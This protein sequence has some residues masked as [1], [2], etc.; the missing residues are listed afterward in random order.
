MSAEQIWTRTGLTWASVCSFFSLTHA[1]MVGYPESLTDPS[2]RGQILV[3]TYPL[4]GNYG[5]PSATEVDA[6]G[7]PHFFESDRVHVAALVVG[8]YGTDYS[9][10][11]AVQSLGAWLKAS[12]V[13]AIHGVD[14]R[15]LTKRLRTNGVMLGKIV[16]KADPTTGDLPF[17][18]PNV[19]NLVAEGAVHCRTT[20]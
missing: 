4:I 8:T 13:P 16:L 5:V 14:T 10:W 18:D 2:Y 9:H 6:N 1:G 20:A 15:A 17:E 3:L 19:R 11:R 7:L 12:N